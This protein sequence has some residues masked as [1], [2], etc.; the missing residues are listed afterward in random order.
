MKNIQTKIYAIIPENQKNE[1][2]VY[3]EKLMK[4]CK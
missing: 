2:H 4:Y 1:V 3:K